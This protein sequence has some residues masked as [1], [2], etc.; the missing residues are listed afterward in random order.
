MLRFASQFVILLAV[1]PFSSRQLMCPSRHFVHFF[2]RSVSFHHVRSQHTLL[3]G[4]ALLSSRARGSS[5]QQITIPFANQLMLTGFHSTA[6]SHTFTSV[7]FSP[8]A[9]NICARLAATGCVTGLHWHRCLAYK[10]RLCHVQ[11]LHCASITSCG[12]FTV[13]PSRWH[14]P[15]ISFVPLSIALWRLAA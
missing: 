12:R 7:A 11:P 14:S 15:A 6:F 1:P 9:A 3:Q 4:L 13:R 8:P 2:L 10:L 5:T